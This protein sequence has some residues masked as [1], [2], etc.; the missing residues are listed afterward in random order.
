MELKILKHDISELNTDA[1]V[2]PSNENLLMGKGASSAIFH[3]AGERKLKKELKQYNTVPIGLSVIT[4]GCNLNAKYIIHS[5][6]PKWIDGNHDEYGYLAAAY[7]SAL[8]VAETAACKTIAFPLMC[9][10]NNGFR[11]DIALGIAKE[12]IENFNKYESISKVYLVLYDDESFDLAKSYELKEIDITDASLF[13]NREKTIINPNVKKNLHNVK[14]DIDKAI[15]DQL[16]EQ[17]LKMIDDPTYAI[18]VIKNGIDT[19]KNVKEKIEGKERK[20]S[21]KKKV[22]K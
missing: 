3:A 10:G 18:E 7:E 17:I 6:V 4:D 13:E 5:V 14:A 21:K 15:K 1:I 8:T 9:A 22:N 2:L 20:E 11:K 16:Y 19:A 12:S